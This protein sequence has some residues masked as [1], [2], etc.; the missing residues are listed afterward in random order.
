MMKIVGINTELSEWILDKPKTGK[1][2]PESG[3]VLPK[4]G[5]PFPETETPN[6][7]TRTIVKIF[8]VSEF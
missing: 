6:T 4:T 5:K 7:R 3:K 8:F 1:L 2:F